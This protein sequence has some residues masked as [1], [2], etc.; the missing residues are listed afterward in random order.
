[1][2]ALRAD[3]RAREEFV[4][5]V[6]GDQADRL[7]DGRVPV[8]EHRGACTAATVTFVMSSPGRA[9]TLEPSAH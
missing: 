9:A 1:M 4:L 5:G 7:V 3:E 2:S 8:Q 6:D